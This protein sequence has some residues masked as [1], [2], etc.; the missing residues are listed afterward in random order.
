MSRPA[1]PTP[2]PD[3]LDALLAGERSALARAITAVEN[4]TPDAPAVLAS[5]YRHLGGAV[6]IGVTGAPGTGKSTLVGALIRALRRRGDS[7]GVIAVDPSSP[8]S[9]GA[10]LGDRVR[11]TEHAGDREVF[12]RSLAARGHLGGLSKTAARVIDV[13]DAAGKD[14]VVVET[15]GVGQSELEVADIADVKLLVTVPGLG[16]EVQAIKAG[17]MEI[18]DIVVVNKADSPLAE[19]AARQL[20]AVVRLGGRG[21]A[22][23]VLQTVAT[24]GDGVSELLEAVDKVAA[25]TAT[26]ATARPSA[27]VRRLLVSLAA[28]TLRRRLQADGAALERLSKRVLRGELGFDDAAGQAI[29]LAAREES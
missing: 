28:E 22:V 27:R 25:R 13:M 15:V 1:S 2:Q 7:V 12:V 9:G 21:K 5:I 14:V 19:A 23:P 16:D 17:V 3:W 6:V 11:M 8:V 20:A 26:S 4:E 29:A 18:A 10:I 24:R